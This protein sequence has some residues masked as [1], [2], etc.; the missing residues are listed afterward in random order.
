[1]TS[2]R[3]VALVFGA[4]GIS[5]WAVANNLVSY[6]TADTFS[7]IIALTH[8]PRTLEE[9]GLPQDSR[10]ELYYGVDLRG[11][12]AQVL[13]QMQEKIPNLA[14]VTHMY[15]CGRSYSAACV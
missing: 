4:S 6:P 11:D 7:R 2:S 12:L 15:Y 1:M 13:G 14:D 10:I 9:S 5:G 3:N 8:R